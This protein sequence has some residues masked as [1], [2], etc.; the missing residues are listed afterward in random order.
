MERIGDGK[1]THV[2][3]DNWIIDGLSR[4]P[5]Y[6]ADSVIDL[7]IHVSDICLTQLQ[8]GGILIRLLVQM[9]CT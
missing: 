1:E 8:N 6:R 2:W 5:N 7:S 4:P 3:G 9:M